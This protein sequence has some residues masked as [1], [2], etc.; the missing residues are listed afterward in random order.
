ME[1]PR[2]C[3]ATPVNLF[4][5]FNKLYNYNLDAAAS[6]EN[7]KCQFYWTR[8]DDAFNKTPDSIDRIWLNPPYC[9]AK[10]GERPLGDWVD[11]AI[12]WSENCELVSLLLPC[13]TG[14]NWFKK[15]FLISKRTFITP[16]VSFIPPEGVN[17]SS[18]R[19]P[20]IVFT[21]GVPIKTEFYDWKRGVFT[22][23]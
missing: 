14:T 20:S 22:K 8:E 11:L 4:E 3:W 2:S 10:F 23:C 13:D 18:N 16:R 1:N 9:G 7:T 6:A 17:Q 15:L 12:S 21:I 19:G 5:V